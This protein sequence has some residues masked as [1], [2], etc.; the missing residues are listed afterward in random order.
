M[1]RKSLSL[2]FT[3]LLITAL[4]PFAALAEDGG[5]EANGTEGAEFQF[6]KEQ[7]A[8]ILA[9]DS[10]CYIVKRQVEQIRN[11]FTFR[12]SSRDKLLD[13]LAME[14]AMEMEALLCK[15]ADGQWSEPDMELLD[16]AMDDLA[17]YI[18]ALIDHRM[19][20]YGITEEGS[21]QNEP[22]NSGE[23]K[24]EARIQHLREKM[25]RLPQSA[26]KGLERAI[27]NAERQR[28]RQREQKQAMEEWT[29]GDGKPPWAGGPGG[30]PDEEE[31]EEEEVVYDPT[32]HWPQDK[33]H[34]DPRQIIN[35]LLDQGNPV[36][37][38]WF[39]A[40]F[41]DGIYMTEAQFQD[42]QERYESYF[43]PSETTYLIVMAGEW[44]EDSQWMRSLDLYVINDSSQSLVFFQFFH[45]EQGE[46]LVLSSASYCRLVSFRRGSVGNASTSANHNF[47][48][49]VDQYKELRLAAVLPFSGDADPKTEAVPYQE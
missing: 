15:I 29:P 6:D 47:M 1:F 4:L 46:N 24:Y 2:L 14:R 3:L 30:R 8:E 17:D 10:P 22:G 35:N 36:G 5:T 25:E 45:Q 40:V 7:L 11:A 39:E 32:V 21:G 9:P 38:E 49:S 19:S 42:F 34:V 13:E 27:A 44:L 33:G 43:N 48:H 31:D 28:E 18:E 41:V 20:T 23:D 16:K 26:Q 37:W 12:G